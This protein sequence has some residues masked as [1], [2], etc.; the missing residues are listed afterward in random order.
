M[1]ARR[2]LARV[3]RPLSPA[4]ADGSAAA[5]CGGCR[6]RAA[7]P[8]A[9]GRAA[10]VLG[11][12]LLAFA[13]SSTTARAVSAGLATTR[14]A[15][16]RLA[17][18]GVWNPSEVRPVIDALE[19]ETRSFLV[20]PAG[21]A[22]SATGTA[23]VDQLDRV[24]GGLT[25]YLDAT[26]AAALERDEDPTALLKSPGYRDREVL[27]L[28]ALYYVSWARYRQATLLPAETATRRDLLNQ[29]VRGF[30]DF[31]F[32]NEIPDLYGDCLYGRALAFQA[33]GKQQN[34]IADL[35]AILELG[36]R[37]PTHARA[38]AARDAV[39]AGKP[40]A[41]DAGGDPSATRFARLR[42]LVGKHGAA[43]APTA[44][45]VARDRY[46]AQDE[47]L[48]I[49]RTLAAKNDADRA[50]VTEI[51]DSVTPTGARPGAFVGFLRGDLAADRGD[52]VAARAHYAGAATAADADA[53]HYRARASFEEAAA[54]YRLKDFAAAAAGFD[55]MLA[56]APS[57]TEAERALYFKAKAIEAMG[58]AGTAAA[59]DDTS[60]AGSAPGVEAYAAALAAYLDRFPQGRHAPELRYR[61]AEI[62][63]QRGRCSAAL[64]VLANP[65]GID[66]W[67]LSGRF[68]A[69]QCA[70]DA[71]ERAR[72]A[73]DGSASDTEY[74]AARDAARALAQDA[75]GLK[76]PERAG[77]GAK[78]ALLGALLAA[79]ATPPRSDDVVRLL[80]GFES[81]FPESGPLYGDA[82]ALRIVARA[83]GGDVDGA[84]A[85]IARLA[86]RDPKP[87]DTTARIRQIG[88]EFLLEADR[89]PATERATW[90]R[91]AQS[92]YGALDGAS[93]DDGAS[94][95]A[96]TPADLAVLGRIAL[97]LND[98]AAATA[99]YA[100]LLALDPES[101]EG[102]RGAALAAEASDHS[103]E[104]LGLW[105]RLGARSTT[106]ETLWYESTL[107]AAQLEERLGRSTDACA[108]LRRARTAGAPAAAP[109]SAAAPL[110]EIERRVCR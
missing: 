70:A 23:L 22:A 78:A 60:A 28:T 59:P 88:R 109:G 24:H 110:G 90:L 54:A 8:N 63:F 19:R 94:K 64:R 14:A 62:E 37:H 106:G 46:P 40:I 80:D 4:S 53:A 56:A 30:T 47:A 2:R 48:A 52:D 103:A 49:G 68:L 17:A 82:I 25:V 91:L 75:A 105:E 26:R 33:L 108:R 43:R 99:A 58:T 98:P 87:D 71:V 57:D 32:V 101:L 38:K 79:A 13:I 55:A 66:A 21:G 3:S 83:R 9:R 5:R 27:S 65:S 69:L 44:G 95:R 93:R 72:R 29:A 107:H 92:A 31:V 96:T 41:L 18:I 100:R 97:D 10:A 1:R 11:A 7:A 89:P 67:D 74:I 34:A 15:V 51:L 81:R 84:R 45:G 36:P 20:M 16:D 73:P 104:A 77:I 102:L 86:A 50:R 42:E 85:D 35:D 12:A 39:R 61:L 6:G 76:D